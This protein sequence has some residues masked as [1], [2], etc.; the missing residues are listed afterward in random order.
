MTERHKP[1][2]LNSG[3]FNVIKNISSPT[4]DSTTSNSLMP[5]FNSCFLLNDPESLQK[6][7]VK[8]QCDT[9]LNQKLCDIQLEDFSCYLQREIFLL[10]GSFGLIM[11][12]VFGIS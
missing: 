7:L 9:D 3:I 12:A 6:E 1:R 2:L 4:K 11:I 10:L 5:N 8:L